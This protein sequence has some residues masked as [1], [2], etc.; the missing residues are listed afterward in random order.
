MLASLKFCGGR[1]G[2][3]GIPDDAMKKRAQSLIYR[4]YVRARCGNAF[5]PE[6]YL[7]QYPDVAAAGLDPYEHY[8]LYGRVE[9]RHPTAAGLFGRSLRRSLLDRDVGGRAR[10]IASRLYVLGVKSAHVVSTEGP[11]GLLKSSQQFLERR[12]APSSDAYPQWIARNEPDPAAL[13]KQAEVAT[14]LKY[15]PRFSII[16]PVWN[17]PRRWL[18]AAIESTLEQTYSNWELCIAEGHSA[19]PH[20]KRL[21]TAYERHDRRIR[22][23]YL[24]ENKGIAEN[25]NAALAMAS[26][27]FV[28]LLD[29][30][31]ELAPF[32]L[33]ELAQLLN[34]KPDLDY[35]YSD[36]DKIDAAGR[37]SA[38]FFKP[39]WSP[40]FLL[41]CGYTNHLSVYRR[42]KVEALGRFCRDV[43]GSQDYDL[44]LRFTDSIAPER[45]GHIPKVLYHWREIPGSTAADP[46]AKD[47]VVLRMARKAL[48]KAMT[49]RGVAASISDGLWP[50]SFHIVRTIPGA[51]LVSIIIPTKDKVDLL[52]GCIQSINEKSTYRNFEILVVDNNSRAPE[53]LSYLKRFP[54]RTIRHSGRFNYSRINNR[55][56][57]QAR[58]D[59]LLFLNNDTEVITPGWIEELL[60]IAEAPGIGAVGC[61]LLYKDGSIQHAGVVL[62]MSPDRNTGIAGHIFRGFSYEDP[63][64]FGAI[65]VVRNYSAVTAA[66]M[67]ISRRIFEEVGG[68]NE[69]LAVCYNDVDLCLRLGE[70]GY[71][72]VYTPFAELFHF[73][74]VTRGSAVDIKEARYM[75]AR[76]G[77]LIKR[78]PFFSPN[79]TLADYNCGLNLM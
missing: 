57:R 21:L 74:S 76:W 71:R 30:D 2:S 59:Y 6:T 22:V 53:T 55:A 34:D 61:K 17:T 10:R 66:C 11:T 70:R 9:G 43:D 77:D 38:P 41:G 36:E 13:A 14:T 64:Y 78:D 32:A 75:L 67:L 19:K 69:E 79:L 40:D 54:G 72:I 62:G 73:E 20:V 7:R 8:A 45:V 16:M 5:S 51:P 23:E 56:A 65:N 46:N 48:E 60:Q 63:G 35:I 68:F 42:Q 47:S 24:D 31:D 52:R 33:F 27:D 39:D 26:G 58:G 1:D 50:G 25:S 12:L 49:R 28:V 15:R 29:H 37:R 3:P 4:L 44:L 18:R